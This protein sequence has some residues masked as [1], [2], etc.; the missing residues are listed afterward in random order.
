MRRC[1]STATRSKRRETGSSRS[2]GRSSETSLEHFL[3]PRAWTLCW[4]LT[5]FRAGKTQILVATDVAARG[6][7]LNTFDII[8]LLILDFAFCSTYSASFCADVDDV[9][10]VINYDFPGA[11][12][13]YIHRSM[14]IGHDQKY[15]TL[16][17]VA[18][19]LP[20]FITTKNLQDRQNWAKRQHWHRL[21][22][23]HPEERE[24]RRATYQHTTGGQAGDPRRFWISSKK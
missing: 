24:K 17:S 15:P 3:S 12:E 18:F 9:K 7:G 11:V 16:R 19:N 23:L 13:D 20:L 4:E 10:F 14:V 8:D 6:L 21:H 2:S 22:L 5:S 1:A